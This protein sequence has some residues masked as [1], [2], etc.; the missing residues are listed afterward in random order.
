MIRKRFPDTTRQALAT[1]PY[2]PTQV[3]YEM[4]SL[5]ALQG[6][7]QEME[8]YYR[9]C[10]EENKEN[11]S[12]SYYWLVMN[13]GILMGDW[14]KGRRLAK[15]AVS[16]SIPR[17]VENF[18]MKRYGHFQMFFRIAEKNR[19]KEID[20]ILKMSYISLNPANK[21]AFIN[22][23][24]LTKPHKRH[25]EISRAG[26]FRNLERHALWLK[27]ALQSSMMKIPSQI[28]DVI[29]DFLCNFLIRS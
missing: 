25:F 12:M 21:D 17:L 19:S 2:S 16:F 15:E 18:D 27:I 10:I 22:W 9:L 11:A 24:K 1:A 7:V 14:E 5:Y 3:Y 29:H 23:S 28:L 26:L 8:R 20:K 6:N 13:F 4:A